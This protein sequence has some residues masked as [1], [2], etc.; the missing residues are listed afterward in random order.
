MPHVTLN[1]RVRRTT[2]ILEARF[3]E[4]ARQLKSRARPSAARLRRHRRVSDYGGCMLNPEDTSR[5]A[6]LLAAINVAV[7]SAEAWVAREPKR[8]EA[9]SISAAP[10]AH[11]AA[12][13]SPR[14]YL[15]AARDGKRIHD[16]CSSPSRSIRRSATRTSDWACIQLRCHRAARGAHPEHAD[17]PP[18]GDLRG[19]LRD[20]QTRSKGCSSRRSRLSASSIYLWY[21]QSSL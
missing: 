16:S 2:L 21:E 10:K 17:V 15:A 1:A 5:D 12:P 9:W 13:R 6:P 3:D 4:A 7:D 18:G 19:R 20:G 14:S 8:A 11:G